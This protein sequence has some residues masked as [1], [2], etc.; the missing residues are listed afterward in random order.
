V[1]NT[2][3]LR[4]DSD[5]GFGSARMVI[6]NGAYLELQNATANL[7]AGYDGDVTATNYLDVAGTVRMPTADSGDGH[8]VAG[9]N[10]V[11]GIIT[12]YPGADVAVSTVN[13]TSAHGEIHFKG[14]TLRATTDNNAFMAGIDLVD[15]GSSGLTVDSAG[16]QIV[17][18]QPL[19]AGV[20]SGGIEKIGSGVLALN[21]TNTYTGTTLVSAGVLAG[22][23]V[24]SG[25]VT[26]GASGTLSPGAPLGALTVNN[27]VTLGGTTSAQISKTGATLA[28]GLLVAS[29]LNCGGLLVVTNIGPD[30][31]AA[32][33]MFNLF[34]ATTFNGTFGSFQLPALVGLA[35]DTSKVAIDGTISLVS[36][37]QFTG[38]S[39]SG[40]TLTLSGA[41]GKP[42]SN[43]YLLASTNIAAP[44]SNW[45]RLQTNVFDGAGNFSTSVTVTPA[46]PKQFFRL[47]VP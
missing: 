21:G 11:P 24:I 46:T 30:P 2:G 27:T 40:S 13:S 19:L 4:A 38:L 28:S 18:A 37:P 41:G 26:V 1:T 43:Y 16:W 15:I 32:G 34:D 23:G 6:T 29:T 44:A 42:N 7:R 20:G 47:L 10:G 12:F 35:W 25:P 9:R 14:G 17:I 5:Q 39:V 36:V 33:D 31:L 45:V 3:A 8:L 22:N